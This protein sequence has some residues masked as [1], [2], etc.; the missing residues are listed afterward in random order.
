M[1]SIIICSVSPDKFSL[2]SDNYASLLGD[3]PFEVIGIHDARSLC[4]GYN[5]GIAQSRGDILIFS[6]DDIEIIT[7][8]FYSRLCQHL[9]QFD[10]IGCAGTTRVV[11]S[12]W[13]YAGD[14]FIHGILAYPV[15]E[16]WPSDYFNLNVWGGLQQTVVEGIQSLD[17]FFLAVNRRIIEAISFD[18]RTFDGF[19]VYD[20]DFTFS[21]YLAGFRLAVCKDLLIA[22][23]SHGNF[24]KEYQKYAARFLEKYRE[25]LPIQD[26]NK[27]QV[28]LARNLTRAQMLRLCEQPRIAPGHRDSASIQI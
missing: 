9:K 1:I 11:T 16:A 25:R 27:R 21:A 15:A 8:D 7:P 17:G 22:H 10:A 20:S 19:H 12:T 13:S 24:G 14:P 26:I 5:R 3:A 6:H 2:V 18:E 4:E 28:L 23:K